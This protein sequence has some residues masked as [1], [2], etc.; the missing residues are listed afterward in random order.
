M[1][2]VGV[3]IKTAPP[4]YCL[5]ADTELT[6]AS[7]ESTPSFCQESSKI[8]YR[9]EVNKEGPQDDLSINRTRKNILLEI[10]KGEK[11]KRKEIILQLSM[12]GQ[13]SQFLC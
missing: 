6:S 9:S 4:G 11:K 5:W 2:L 7:K 1:K 3:S 10:Q 12:H 13:I 8:L